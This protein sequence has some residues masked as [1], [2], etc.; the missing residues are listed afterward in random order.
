M[1]APAS[2]EIPPVPSFAT[3]ELPPAVRAR[4]A[5]ARRR[6]EGRPPSARA[7]GELGMLL[8]AYDQLSSARAAYE[9]A[10]ALDPGAFEWAY[11]CGVVQ[12][13]MGQ[14]TE[15]ASALREAVR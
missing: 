12:L 1:T 6:A 15:A 2:A 3:D 13:R 4:A 8:H 14:R 10:R 9:R 7:A 5:A 11:L